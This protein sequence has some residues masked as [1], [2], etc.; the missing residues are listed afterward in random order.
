MASY[1]LGAG[2]DQ[3]SLT[4]TAKATLTVLNV[5]TVIGAAG[6][7]Q[8]TVGS[9]T[10]GMIVNLGSGVDQLT[11]SASGNTERSSG[12]NPCRATRAA[13]R[14]RSAAPSQAAT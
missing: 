3:I 13:M 6:A 9:S 7:D 14:S 5:E 11:L 12:S 10:T 2:N 8:V 1:D 4:A